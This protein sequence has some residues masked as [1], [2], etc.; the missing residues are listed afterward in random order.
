MLKRAGRTEARI[1]E[2]IKRYEEL[3]ARGEM[4]QDGSVTPRIQA[5]KMAL[6]SELAR[7]RKRKQQALLQASKLQA[8]RQQA[9]MH[10]KG[11]GT[12]L[13][14]LLVR[15]I[16]DKAA[17]GN[18]I[19]ALSDSILHVAHAKF[20]NGIEKLRTR[21]LGWEQ[22][23]ELL[24]DILVAARGGEPSR[25]EAA[26][27]AEAWLE[28]ANGLRERFNAAGGDIKFR[29]DWGSPQSHM[30]EKL[31][32][33]GKKA[34]IETTAPLLDRAKMLDSEGVPMDDKAL[35]EWL[36]AAYDHVV[37][38]GASS[39][40][41]TH[42]KVANRHQ[43]PRLL[44]FS[45]PDAWLK[46][47]DAFGDEDLFGVMMS[48]LQHLS[49]EVAQME[50]L[51][52]N[53][54]HAF[55][56]LRSEVAR[57]GYAGEGPVPGLSE[58]AKLSALDSIFQQVTGQLD[59][60]ANVGL[61]RV[62]G[63]VRHFLSSALLGAATLS[64]GGDIGTSALAANYNG[65]P[66]WRTLREGLRQMNPANE[67]DRVAALRMGLGFDAMGARMRAANLADIGG[68]AS[69]LSESV[70]RAS[71]LQSWT[72]GLRRGFGMTFMGAMADVSGR[73]LD[74]ADKGLGG[75][76]KR[77]GFTEAEWDRL[78]SVAPMDYRGAK[79]V[80]IENILADETM[81][82]AQKTG[83]IDRVLRM[84]NS[85]TGFAVP[86]PGARSMAALAAGTQRGTVSG[87]VVRSLSL[88]KSFAAEMAGTHMARA[89]YQPTRMKQGEYVAKLV[90]AS[91]VFG[92][93]SYQAKQV[94]KGRD[95]IPFDA[96]HAPQLLGAGLLQ[97]GGLGIGGDFLVSGLTSTDRYGRGFFSSQSGPVV[98]VVDDL[99]KFGFG[100]AGAVAQG[101]DPRTAQELTRLVGRYTPGSSLWYAR[102]GFQR[103]L[104]QVR[105]GVDPRGARRSFRS[106][107]NFARTEFDT[108]YWWRPGETRPRRGPSLTGD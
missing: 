43:H 58:G 24:R 15:D 47:N 55:D 79:W 34:W 49:N 66:I 103:L 54:Q 98:G 93:A 87:E 37:T 41:A 30:R 67:A 16:T 74:E 8:A 76:L 83:L 46:Y 1:A 35:A 45:S 95:P 51:G 52:P 32:K 39:L 78:R 20:A 6:E 97:G 28:A 50:V 68:L 60:P 92:T 90:L 105:L 96:E 19:E 27:Y 29:N 38:D 33:A 65:L 63:G 2:T 25:P 94:A 22:D 42:G 99:I 53:P 14:S 81:T 107:E 48:H 88:F 11:M 44:A 84:V 86:E 10:P 85:E 80:S 101:R 61:A 26:A 36:S 5:E 82:A 18:N 56:I 57:V 13:M 40:A 102:L 31:H 89:F 23:R 75:A 91:A 3:L 71:G 12:G 69:K 7:I 59:V 108:G 100:G 72:E 17:S 70:I 4:M 64:S 62:F 73:S 21:K 77:Y 104:D 9:A 106:Q